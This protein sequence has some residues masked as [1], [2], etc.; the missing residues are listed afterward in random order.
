MKKHECPECEKHAKERQKPRPWYKVRLYQVLIVL[1]IL[2][3]LNPVLLSF[4]IGALQEFWIAF[5]DYLLLIWWAIVLG[6]VIGGI[7]DYLVPNEYI[8]K[9]LS[10]P[11]KRTIGWSVL[12]GFL[13][14]AC[15]HG[16]LAI[17]MEFYKKG[18]SVP[19]VVAFLMASPWANLPITILLFSFFGINAFL[20]IISAIIIAIITGFIYQGLDRK[21]W[22]ERSKHTCKDCDSFSVKADMKKRWKAYRKHPNTANVIKGVAGGG[23]SLAKMVLWWI[24][25]GMVFAS[26]A[27]VF[28]HPELFMSFLG[29]TL[30][31]LAV[32]LVIATVIEVC[33]EGSAPFAFEIFRQTGALG[34]SFTFL[35]AGVATDYTEVGIIASNIGRRAAIWLPIITVPQ[36]LVL[37]YLFNLFL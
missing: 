24:L 4:G 35:M 2:F 20:I 5:Y 37:G 8:T 6:F 28:I 16:I 10:K 32:T 11:E 14:S 36:I 23:W 34:N 1:A 12:L 18:A 19:A 31:G 13:M 29:P 33:S 27:R 30:V 25:I 17:S 26:A 22:I 21:G 7:I 3:A 9:F 15:S